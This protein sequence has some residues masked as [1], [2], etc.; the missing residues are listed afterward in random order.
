MIVYYIDK[1]FRNGNLR[2][3]LASVEDDFSGTAETTKSW[4]FNE[5][6]QLRTLFG[7]SAFLNFFHT[8]NSSGL[9]IYI[10]P[11]HFWYFTICKFWSQNTT[12]VLFV[13]SVLSSRK[14]RESVQIVFIC[15]RGTL[16]KKVK[17]RCSVRRKITQ[18]NLSIPKMLL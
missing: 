9:P 17:D 18:K 10:K 16:N 4:R 2:E 11:W 15:F 5:R 12:S 6:K 14:V 8:R 1:F 3:L 7:Y 13:M